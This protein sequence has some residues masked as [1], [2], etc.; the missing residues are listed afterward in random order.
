MGTGGRK[1]EAIVN[2]RNGAGRVRLLPRLSA[3]F[4]STSTSYKTIKYGTIESSTLLPYVSYSGFHQQ[5][6]LNPI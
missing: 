2:G 4:D 1:R 3:L 6:Q 5:L